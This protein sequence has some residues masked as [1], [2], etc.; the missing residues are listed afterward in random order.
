[1][2][3]VRLAWGGVVEVED[4]IEGG[5]EGEQLVLVDCSGRAVARF[6]RLDVKAFGAERGSLHASS[7]REAVSR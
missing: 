5:I 4:A 1:L 6:P 7:R 3:F 2:L